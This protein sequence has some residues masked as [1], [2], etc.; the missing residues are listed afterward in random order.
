VL[1]PIETKNLTAADVEDMT[2]DTLD[3]MLKE[4]IDLTAKQREKSVSVS[5]ANGKERVVKASGVQA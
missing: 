5:S 3:L 4:I 2:R 1:K